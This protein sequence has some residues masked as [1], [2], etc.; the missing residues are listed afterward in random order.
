MEANLSVTQ[1]RLEVLNLKL[2]STVGR[3]KGVEAGGEDGHGIKEGVVPMLR[4]PARTTMSTMP[5]AEW[6]VVTAKSA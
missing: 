1:N 5:I 3:G 2:S 4:E 6:I